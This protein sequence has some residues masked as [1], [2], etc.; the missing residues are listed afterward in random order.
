MTVAGFA[1]LVF[2]ALPA[3]PAIA[4][5]APESASCSWQAT[6]IAVP[7]G[8]ERR[9]VSVDT[10]DGAG[11][12]FGHRAYGSGKAGLLRWQGDQ[13]EEVA[14]PKGSDSAMP[15][16]QNRSGTALINATVDGIRNE[17]FLY[18]KGKYETLP[19]PAPYEKPRA[20]AINDRGDVVAMAE[21]PDSTGYV[22]I[23]WFAYGS[24]P[25]V[26]SPPELPWASPVDI[27]Q[28]GTILISGGYSAYLWRSGELSPLPPSPDVPVVTRALS[29]G[30]AVGTIIGEK[31]QAVLWHLGSPHL[32]EGGGEAEDINRH[33]L[34]AGS[35]GDWNGPPAVWRGT[36]L[37]AKLPLP[38]DAT[39]AYPAIASDDGT[40]VGSA[41]PDIGPVRWRCT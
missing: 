41:E 15:A 25:L 32:L 13:P 1:G 34:I 3:T 18:R 40:I 39:S 36:R 6:P 5:P 10:T 11:S 14:L 19:V 23:A 16:D 17:V 2:S 30:R 24:G 26:I 38:Q 27:D 12:Y 29:K 22:V 28:D 9:L 21:K 7:P 20:V 33:G 37:L 35:A 31:A 4:L 8:A